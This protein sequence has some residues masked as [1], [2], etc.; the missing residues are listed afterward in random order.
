MIFKCL[1]IAACR[2]NLFWKLAAEE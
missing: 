1:G 2:N